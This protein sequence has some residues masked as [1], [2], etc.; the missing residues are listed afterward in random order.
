MKK[1]LRKTRQVRELVALGVLLWRIAKFVY[2][3]V[4]L[5]VIC[6]HTPS[7]FHVRQLQA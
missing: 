7:F 5:T 3:H 1:F 2:E 6:F 4:Y